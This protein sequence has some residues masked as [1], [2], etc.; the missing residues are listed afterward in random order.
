MPIDYLKRILT[1]RVYDVARETP[2]EPAPGLSERI[3]HR[4]LLKREDMQSVF[5]FKLRG[6]YNK[7]VRLSEEERARGVIAASAGNHA[8]GVALAAQHL[9]CRAVIVMPVT[10]PAVKVEAVRARQAQ[11]VLA[12]DSYSDAYSHALSLQQKHGL[13]FVHPFDDP[14]VIAGQGTIGMEILRQHPDPIEAIFVAIGGGGLIGGIAAY[15][16]QI[17]PEIQ[18]IGVQTD[19]SNAMARSLACGERV[20]LSEVGLFSDGTAVKQVGL[21][22]FALAR[23]F[24]DEVICVNTDAICAAIKDVFQ[25][26]RS[27]MEPAGALSI[28]GAKAWAERRGQARNKTLVAIACGANMNFDRLRF[29]SERAEIGEQREAIFAVTI[30]E[31]RGSFKRFCALIG[32]R[33][34]TEFNYRMSDLKRAHVFVG[35]QIL[36]RQEANE[37]AAVF[38]RDGLDAIN[39]T[40]DEMAKLHI[41]HLVGGSSWHA[42]DERLFRFEFPERP[43]AL[44]R[45]LSQMRPDWNISL[46]HYR[47][48]GADFGR[49]LVGL[50][51]PQTDEAAFQHFLE[52][53]GYPH[54][55]ETDNPAYHL[56]LRPQ[57]H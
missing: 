31:E 36:E 27:I 35:I 53:L 8:Q 3:G 13:I 55:E 24:V 6:A 39:L 11:V 17:R 10:T 37:I 32:E 25:D 48:H 29:V 21:E 26:T 5:S 50:Q 41:R 22:T 23:Q 20:L 15:V 14:D 45:F 7:M 47:N 1:A 38:A 18:I 4:L 44:S 12:G 9:G 49:V 52:G 16:K 46:F 2:L 56:F 33:N 51:V 43:G 42:K 57:G 19:D 40:D 28:A 54:L 30:P 34:V